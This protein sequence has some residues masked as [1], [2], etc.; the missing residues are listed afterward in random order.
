M[1]GSILIVLVLLALILGGLSLGAYLVAA[2]KL[3]AKDK[4]LVGRRRRAKANTTTGAAPATPG[5]A[6]AAADR[7]DKRT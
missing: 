7:D 5:P 2:D 3:Y 1:P 6:E 4:Q